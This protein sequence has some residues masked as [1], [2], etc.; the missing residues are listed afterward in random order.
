MATPGTDVELIAGGTEGRPAERGVWVQNMWRP[1]GSPNWQTRP[2]FGQ[3]AQLDTTLRAG[4]ATE[5]GMTKH[6]GSHLVQT[7][8]GTEQIVSVFLVNARSGTDTIDSSSRWGSYYSVSIFDTSTGNHYEQVL[9]RHTAQNKTAAFGEYN[10]PRMEEWYGNYSTNETYDNQS[11]LYG[12]D[13]PFYFTMY[14]NNLFFGN[15]LTGLLSYLPA[16][17]RESRDQTV[18]STQSNDWVKGYSEDCL[19][20]KVV[21][22]DGPS[23]DALAYLT[24]QNFPA[25]VAITTLGGRFVVASESQ[26][27][28]SDENFPNA[29]IDGNAVNVPSKNPVIAIA[30]TG[31][32]LAVF[33]E[34]EMLLF[35][36][37]QGALLA[38]G[39]FTVVSRNVGCLSSRTLTSVGST[40]FWADTN[41][42]YAS[43]NGLQI[44]ELSKPI[45]DFFK[46]GITCPLN[47]YLTAAGVSNPV[48]DAQ[49]RTLY[50]QSDSE[51]ISIAYSQETESLF[52]SYPGSNAL[53][54]Y[55]QGGWSLW[56]V[57]STVKES[58]GAAVVGVQQNITN[59]YVMTGTR[60]VFL[61]GSVET[62]TFTSATTRAETIYSSSYYLMQL[63][64]GGAI[65]RSIYNEDQRLV[66]GE[67]KK[68]ATA[69]AGNARAYFGK[70][71]YD[72]LGGAAL[73]ET[74][75]IP[76]EIVPDYTAVPAG[77]PVG[78]ELIFTYDK[79]RWTPG[80]SLVIPPERRALNIAGLTYT[81]TPATSTI[82]IVY[83]GGG[84]PLAFADKQRNP[85]V[86]LPMTPVSS[87]ATLLDYGF[88]F[89]GAGAQARIEALGSVYTSLSVYIWNQH[90]GPLH[91]NND[92]AQPVDWAY[93]SPQVGIESADHIKA[94]GIFARMVTHGA[95]TSPL[96]PNWIWGVYNTLLGADWKG[97]TSQVIDF[98]S[99]LVK[100]ADKFPLRTRYK[101]TATSSM[102]Y[103]RFNATPKYGEYL[104]DD[105]E[106]D[107]I[108]TSDSVKGAYL[109][110]MMFGFMRDRA[111]KVE[112]ASAK[113]VIRPGGTRRRTGR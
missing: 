17:F 36:P 70:P 37:S 8:W 55:N 20:T 104:V 62:G 109:S 75:W 52:V 79:T 68:R 19:V 74:H 45:N 30:E 14:Q 29:F 21:P 43:S 51:D 95:G 58:G 42:V 69:A 49:P 72:A 41:G 9:F 6:L 89:S 108:A 112:I 71:I 26:L 110:Y 91:A 64:R 47:N 56:P 84:T 27:L 54:C 18:D 67:F 40:I 16:D 87:A 53:W 22:I 100:I 80:A 50:R 4:I 83:A 65:D 103:R 33:T 44:E 92:V 32:N 76:I 98:S 73:T 81:V 88:D 46:G 113:A 11:F 90:Y 10:T 48:A 61:V 23:I 102:K 78:V 15:R 94:R 34:T 7:E 1:K 3:M 28:F 85:F 77:F 38:P 39:R 93:K 107:T 99:G 59:P 82:S 5:W 97:W 101:D 13:D 63:G 86:L 60:E 96:S 106:H 25:P 66:Y 24:E 35:Q 2:G 12:I 31:V 111:E 105:E 57:E